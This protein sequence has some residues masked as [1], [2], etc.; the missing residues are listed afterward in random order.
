MKTYFAG[1]C[2]GI[3]FCLT[4]WMP[5]YAQTPLP[6]P[7]DLETAVTQALENNFA[8]Q[9]A[10]QRVVRFGG[11]RIHANRLTPSN[12]QLELSVGRR[13]SPQDTTHDF[14]I[15][16]TQEVWIAGQR[17]LN[18][19]SAQ[20]RLDAARS[21]AAFLK[22]AIAART[23]QAFL[24]VLL[25]EQAV[26]TARRAESLAVE[27]S[28]IADK[29]LERGAATQLEVNAAR[30]GLST[31]QVALA[32]AQKD[33]LQSRLVLAEL[34]AVDPEDIPALQ[35]DIAAMGDVQLPD[36]QRIMNL[37]AQQRQDLAAAAERVSAASAEFQLAKREVIPNLRITGFYEQEEQSDIFGARLSFD[38]PVLH[39]FSGERQAAAAA[40]NI[41]ETNRQALLLAIRREI[42]GAVADY[43]TAIKTV[44]VLR[45]QAIDR[46][47]QTVELTR[48]S[49]SAGRLSAFEIIAAQDSLLNTRDAYL[50]ALGNLVTAATDLE[51]AS[52]GLL[53][54]EARQNEKTTSREPAV[55]PVNS[56]GSP[57]EINNKGA[58][59]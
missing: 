35:G 32:N 57:A 49:F 26:S 48:K 7:L 42:I 9:M 11:D 45:D 55:T 3:L 56:S 4:W 58:T 6:Q 33:R 29:R 37:A 38:L 16:I 20:S 51:R 19:R 21:D 28:A 44:S 14:G 39:T 34:L 40:L 24:L 1:L 30:V 41:A 2:A 23:R 36:T 18:Q 27:L 12:P 46:A 54:L 13:E 31:A 5:V 15:G 22:L 17:G 43:R 52:G 50:T 25:A 53:I 59:Q 8:I 47:E 10:E